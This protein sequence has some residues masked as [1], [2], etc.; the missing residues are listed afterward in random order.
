[1]PGI[2]LSPL[3][4]IPFGSVPSLGDSYSLGEFNFAIKALPIGGKIQVSFDVPGVS[5]AVSW[6][7]ELKIL[8]KRYEWANAEDDSSAT[9]IH[10]TTYPTGPSSVTIEDSTDLV[11]GV[12]YYYTLYELRVDDEWITDPV[13][14]RKSA[15]PFSRWGF[16]DYMYRSMPAGWQRADSISNGG[17]GDL[18]RFLDIFGASFDSIKSDV[19][20]LG[21]LYEIETIHVDLLPLLDQKIGWPT[22]YAAGGIKQRKETGVASDFF[23][24]VGTTTAITAACE[25]ISAFNSDVVEGWKYVMFSNGLYGCTTPDTDDSDTLANKGL[26]TDIIKYTN[27][28]TTIT[29]W[30]CVNGI[31]VFL[32][33]SGTVT[34]DALARY[35]E[36]LQFITATFVNIGL[37]NLVTLPT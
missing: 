27:D 4:Y 37:I 1:M 36:M 23:Q 10:H 15:F 22:W 24:I 29:S 17:T 8:R 6:K 28:N 26:K 34:S 18:E 3:G 12:I 11:D 2:G 20:H 5:E 21:T 14:G 13:V 30:Y 35:D 16:S 33:G 19:E 31:G 25:D 32:T 7:R 9:E